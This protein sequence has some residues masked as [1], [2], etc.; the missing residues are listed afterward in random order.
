[1]PIQAY[2][3]Y[4]S[5]VNFNGELKPPPKWAPD[6]V[7]PSCCQCCDCG[8]G[9]SEPGI[10][11]SNGEIRL[12]LDILPVHGFGVPWGHTLAYSNRLP[13]RIDLGNGFRWFVEQWPR[14]LDFDDEEGV[15]QYYA[16]VWSPWQAVWFNVGEARAEFEYYGEADGVE[17]PGA[18]KT[19]SVQVLD[20]STWKATGT[21]FFRYYECGETNGFCQALKFM[22]SPASYE[23]LKAAYSNPVAATDASS[24]PTR[25]DISSTT[26][27]SASPRRSS[28]AARAR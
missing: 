14:V 19:I 20:G 5:P 21:Y 10:R 12:E 1:M 17:C 18:L 28:T 26:R 22:F 23:R 13:E 2:M 24:R 25:I 4:D 15:T 27:T 16:A 7:C 9:V 6:P 11:Y 8:I 3:G